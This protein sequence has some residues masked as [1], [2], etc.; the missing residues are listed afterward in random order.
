M[1]KVCYNKVRKDFFNIYHILVRPRSSSVKS[2]IRR[3]TTPNP[4]RQSTVSFSSSAPVWRPNGSIKH[5]KFIGSHDPPSK[6]KPSSEP[7]WKPGGTATK[8]KH[9]RALDPASKSMPKKIA[10]PVWQ[11]PSKN[12]PKKTPKYFEPALKPESIAPTQKQTKP[13]VRK[14][15][16]IPSGDPNLKARIAN[17][18]SKV[19][20]RWNEP[21][22]TLTRPKPPI[23]PRP[24]TVIPPKVK[25]AP[26]KKVV[27]PPVPVK[28]D[29]PIKTDTGR[30]SV[31]DIPIQ[32]IFQS[33]PRSQSIN[34]DVDDLFGEESQ[35]SETSKK[36][37]ISHS[38]PQTKI[39]PPKLRMS[40]ILFFIF[41]CFNTH[42]S[43]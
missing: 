4:L 25:S 33:T 17:A 32:P 18:E 38:P 19:E 34:H 8:T 10:E 7:T 41:N 35:A 30:S 39:T 29:A 6:P 1:A 31:T 14:K 36:P 24:T 43:S 9:F 12:H 27:S 28:T 40:S 13:L 22:Q 20:T 5:P 26:V 42:I 11:P 37:T 21:P 2:R 23:V 16:T 15:P 3:D